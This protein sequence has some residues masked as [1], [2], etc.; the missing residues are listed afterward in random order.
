MVLC[1]LS[2]TYNLSR[3]VAFIEQPSRRSHRRVAAR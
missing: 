3:L 2:L 1:A